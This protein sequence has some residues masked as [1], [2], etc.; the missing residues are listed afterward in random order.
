MKN[1]GNQVF[2]LVTEFIES[3]IAVQNIIGSAALAVQWGLRFF[4]TV[5]LLFTPLPRGLYAGPPDVPV[6]LNEHNR[7]TRIG[8]PRLIQQRAVQNDQPDGG[9]RPGNVHLPAA[10]SRDARVNQ[11]L[12]SRSLG[13]IAKNDFRDLRPV[14]TS[15]RSA[16]RVTPPLP[17]PADHER[18]VH[19]RPG[20]PVRVDDTRP[21]VARDPRDGGLAGTD[22]AGQSDDGL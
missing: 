19:L 9:V 12:Q 11:R 20:D 22:S 5:K 21:Q 7:V 8:Q 10:P 14:H 15:I 16:N 13:R 4:P 6:C 3:G 18:I 1:P 2:D 17:Q